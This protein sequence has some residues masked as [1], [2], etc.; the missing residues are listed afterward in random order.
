MSPTS[1]HAAKT[2]VSRSS[3]RNF[4][5]RTFDCDRCRRRGRRD[6][7]A[8][9]ADVGASNTAATGS[10]ERGTTT[11]ARR[12]RA[13]PRPPRAGPL[14]DRPRDREAIRRGAPGGG[15]AGPARQCSVE[16][17]VRIGQLRPARDGQLHTLALC[18]LLT[19]TIPPCSHTGLPIHFQVSLTPRQG[20][21]D[22]LADLGQ[23]LPSP[24]AQA[25]D[26]LV[27]LPLS[28]LRLEHARTCVT[29]HSG[30]PSSRATQHERTM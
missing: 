4:W 16:E 6:D 28:T 24:V 22:Q 21:V 11:S 17:A 3:R 5:S 15:T 25:R 29:R 20:V 7:L 13:A 10:A 8:H 23:P 2:V 1:D 30:H 12:R 26:E 18:A 9:I 19:T 14:S 27:D